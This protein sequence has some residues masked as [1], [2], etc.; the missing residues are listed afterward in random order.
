MGRV[1]KISNYKS[2]EILQ[3]VCSNQTLFTLNNT[4][5][6]VLEDDHFEKIFEDLN[7]HKTNLTP[8]D[9]VEPEKEMPWFQA[10]FLVFSSGAFHYCS[11]YGLD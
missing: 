5:E 2:V 8:H 10:L 7:H 9:Y 4:G 11:G 3:L 6:K 1:R